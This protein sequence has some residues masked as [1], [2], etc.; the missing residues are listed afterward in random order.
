MGL[1]F[2]YIISPLCPLLPPSHGRLALSVVSARQPSHHNSEND[3][4]GKTGPLIN[5][6]RDGGVLC[7][8][9]RVFGLFALGVYIKERDL[10]NSL[11]FSSFSLD[12]SCLY[13]CFILIMGLLFVLRIWRAGSLSSFTRLHC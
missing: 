13:H 2:E 4:G 7:G 10:S 9:T 12:L 6:V 5:S 8:P 11:A 1:T 3:P